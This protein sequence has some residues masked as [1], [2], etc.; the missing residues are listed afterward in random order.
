MIITRHACEQFRAR[1]STDGDPAA[2]IG[3][4]LSGPCQQRE[5]D[6][7][8]VL[9]TTQAPHAMRCVLGM[10]E[11][12]SPAITTVMPARRD[13]GGKGRLKA[14]SDYRSKARSHVRH[15]IKCNDGMAAMVVTARLESPLSQPDR[16][17]PTLDGILA[18][19]M[20]RRAAGGVDGMAMDDSQMEAVTGLPLAI[21]RRFD[22]WW[23]CTSI[24]LIDPAR[25]WSH[26]IHRRF[27]GEA[28]GGYLS[29]DKKI[30]TKAGTFRS[31]RMPDQ[32]VSLR[33]VSWA[34]I[35]DAGAVRD[36]LSTVTHVGAGRAR[37][38]GQVREWI[39]EP[40]DDAAATAIFH[41]PLP[42]KFA[43]RYA[44]AGALRE[45]G[46]RPPGRL[47]E[48]R[49]LCAIPDAL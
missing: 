12:G 7:G 20:V 27:D 22:D 33:Y 45:C 15:V 44:I 3:A 4:S 30:S 42:Q 48:N 47:P 39:V 23:Y 38:Y 17:S 46:I 24:P 11:D 19:S 35:G 13:H 29:G 36:L 28:K 8:S 40:A 49:R 1:I 31:R 14:P 26:H 32:L 5:R 9:I 43:E 10:D 37:G 25:R 6:D 18:Y 34:A 41:R 16:L 2:E 21:D